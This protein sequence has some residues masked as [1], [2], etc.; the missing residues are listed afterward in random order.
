MDR[1][2][3][4][5]IGG[6]K[7]EAMLA[8]S[9][10][11]VLRK[12]FTTGSGRKDVISNI[13]HAVEDVSSGRKVSAVGIGIAGFLDRNGVMSHSPNIKGIEG[14]DLGKV[15]S[16]KL[17]LPVFVLNDSKCFAL[18]EYHYGVGKGAGNFVG[19]IWGTG[20]GSGIIIDGR[21]VHGGSNLAGEIGHHVLV[22][23]GEMCTCGKRGHFEQYVAARALVGAYQ[24]FKGSS[25]AIPPVEIVKKNDS[26]SRKALDQVAYHMG[27]GLA[28]VVQFYDP[29]VIALG[30]GMSNLTMLYPRIRKVMS[31]NIQGQKVKVLKSKL[32]DSSG[33]YGAL[34]LAEKQG[35][36]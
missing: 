11:Q 28:N 36:V 35:R 29:E 16:R 10:S 8:G 21:L 19:L 1:F 12:R 20:V 24:R 14:V 31:K 34:A 2:V 26:A 22:A 6:T 4:L 18:S 13:L 7:I 15:L 25:K 32:G 27:L 3:A 23:D 30:G 33:I 5:D 9:R 17:D